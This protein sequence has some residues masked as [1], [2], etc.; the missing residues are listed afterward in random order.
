MTYSL[1][2]YNAFLLDE[3]TDEPGA[4]LIVEGKIRAVFKGYFTNPETAQSLAKSILEEDGCASNC[5]F[6]SY[7]AKGLT[8]TPSFVDMHV[9]FRDP[10][11]THKEDIESGLRAAAAGGFGT[12][13]AMPN[14]QPVIS[15]LDDALSVD[16][17]AY[18][19][20]LSNLI[21]SVSITSGFD[22]KSVSHI[23]DLN[24]RQVPLITE[25]GH[26]V[27][28]ASVMLDAMTRA[29]ENGIIV[30]CHCEDPELAAEAKPFRQRALGIMASN[31]LTAWGEGSGAES[32]SED[33][34]EELN[35]ALTQANRLL[36][37][38]EDIATERNIAVAREADCRIHICHV[39]T[40]RAVDAIRSAKLEL[41]DDAEYFAD[42]EADAAYDALCE[43]ERFVP[44][45]N[46]TSGFDITCEVTPH[47]IALCGTEEPF[48]RA[49]VNPPLRS[50]EDRIALIEALRDG[51]IDCIAT[52]HAPHTL[53]DKAEGAPG[54][55]GL[56]TAYA[57][58][59][60]VLVKEGQIDSKR[61]SA[62]M[63]ANPARILHLNKG[64]LRAGYDGDITLID[65]EEL[66]TVNSELFYSKGKASPFNGRTLSG[67]VKTVFIAGRKIFER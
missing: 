7:D 58:C 20:G 63:S 57:V 9:H 26:D 60:T 1:L 43:G 3:S 41:F 13:V 48:I 64:L 21:Q 54:F 35:L 17:R 32:L 27:L 22:G 24:N 16:K 2:I 19:L 52:D 61:L 45:K 10:G 28:S 53:Q 23:S 33:T 40:A 18:A 38:A 44:Q 25:D 36:E 51:T 30:S 37:L 42:E 46:E 67:K 34:A 55:T 50:E 4:V 31:G 39:S 11:Q 65:P 66:W 8:L 14:T 6:E 5:R 47:H 12:V 62:L 49:L 29:A 59:N 15:S 56:E